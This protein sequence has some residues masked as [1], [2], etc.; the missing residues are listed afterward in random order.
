MQP[1]EEEVC[2]SLFPFALSVFSPGLDWSPCLF[3]NA[4]VYSPENVPESFANAL[5]GACCCCCFGRPS[6]DLVR[7]KAADVLSSTSLEEP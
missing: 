7:S 5:V 6:F 1:Q 3:G 2:V 4:C